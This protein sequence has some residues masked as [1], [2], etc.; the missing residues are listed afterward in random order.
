MKTQQ[1][2][3]RKNRKT[4]NREASSL[5]ITK[6]AATDILILQ[7]SRLRSLDNY[8]KRSQNKNF[9]SLKP[10]KISKVY[11]QT[12]LKTQLQSKL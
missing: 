7:L 6:K 4:K 9:R 5:K 12:P 8:L 2:L 10:T 11:P 1:K 3:P